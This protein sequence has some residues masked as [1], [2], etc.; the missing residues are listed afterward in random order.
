M[1]PSGTTYVNKTQLPRL[2]DTEVYLGD[3]LSFGELTMAFQFVPIFQPERQKSALD[4]A[5]HYVEPR[6]TAKNVPKDYGLVAGMVRAMVK[7]GTAQFPAARALLASSLL[8]DPNNPEGWA[9]VTRCC[10]VT[11]M[12]LDIVIIQCGSA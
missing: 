1:G 11:V 9:Q 6:A 7:G 5:L 2:V 8:R 3:I 10:T 12:H 4:N